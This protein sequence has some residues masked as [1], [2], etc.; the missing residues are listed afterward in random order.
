MRVLEGGKTYEYEG[1]ANASDLFNFLQNK[2]YQA[3]K[4]V[5][6]M[7]KSEAKD[8]IDKAYQAKHAAKKTM[9]GSINSFIS[10]FFS[11]SKDSYLAQSLEWLFRVFGFGALSL[12]TKM[13]G[14]FMVVVAPIF[15]FL[16]MLLFPHVIA[17]Q[18]EKA[19]GQSARPLS[20]E[21]IVIEEEGS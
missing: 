14:F 7:T 6:D 21:N 8:L 18:E 13:I 4:K 9:W 19:A 11:L 12:T 16:L 3:S 20:Q 2:A 15:L 5:Y 1:Q 17:I 10:Q